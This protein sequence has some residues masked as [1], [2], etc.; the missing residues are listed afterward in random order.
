MLPRVTYWTQLSLLVQWKLPKVSSASFAVEL[1]DEIDPSRVQSAT[2]YFE[3]SEPGLKG[4]RLEAWEIFLSAPED[5]VLVDN[6]EESDDFSDFRFRNLTWLFEKQSNGY[7]SIPAPSVIR[8]TDFKRHHHH[9]RRQSV[10]TI[11][12]RPGRLADSVVPSRPGLVQVSLEI[13]GSFAHWMAY[14]KRRPSMKKVVRTILVVCPKCDNL[15]DPIDVKKVRLG[16][17]NDC[18]NRLSIANSK[19]GGL[20]D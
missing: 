1:A 3:T 18:A 8:P 4:Q 5:E 16:I 9:R 15:V 19:G 17:G 7:T 2:L 13:S 12:I 14:K 6:E 10:D 20:E 11:R